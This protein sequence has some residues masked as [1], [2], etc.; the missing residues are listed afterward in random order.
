MKYFNSLPKVVYS[1]KNDVRTIY[2]NIMAR[3]SVTPSVMKNILVYYDYDIQEQDTPEIIAHKYY[4]DINRF[5]MVLYCNQI[6]DPL[7]DWPLNSSKFQKYV[8]NKYPNT[9]DDV[10]HYEI[11]KTK[12][13]QNSL[14]EPDV[15]KIVCSEEEYNQIIPNQ[16]MSYTIG[17]EVVIIDITKRAVTNYEY[18]LEL[19]ESKRSIKIL[20]K[21]YAAQ[22]EKEFV[23][24][25]KS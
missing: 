17:S 24:L 22:L 2:T 23:E 6:N 18:E 7:W 16:T 25:M 8:E 13:I 9:L 19:N 20:N 1:D 21:E 15:E 12:S 11:I 14:I 5:W 3:A 10:H 4:G